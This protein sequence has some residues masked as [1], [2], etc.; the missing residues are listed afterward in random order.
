V[1][2]VLALTGAVTVTVGVAHLGVATVQYTIVSL[3][4]L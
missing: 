2:R 4:A 1:R 3:D